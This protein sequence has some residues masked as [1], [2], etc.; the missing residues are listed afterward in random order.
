MK[1][2]IFLSLI[3]AGLTSCDLLDELIPDVET[4]YERNFHISITDNS[5]FTELELIDVASSEDYAEFQDNINGYEITSIVIS[6]TAYNGPED[7]YFNGTI[8]ARD[9]TLTVSVDVADIPHT[10]ISTLLASES[11]FDVEEIAE[12]IDQVI[13]W[14]DDPGKF[15]AQ[16]S[17]NLTDAMGE[18]YPVSDEDY[19]IDLMV[20]YYVTVITGAGSSSEEE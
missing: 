1:K 10:N 20:K 16:A 4:D 17:Y 8:L 14:L 13:N 15:Y 6:V 2:W 7:M 9:T 12:G 5:G 18:P 19:S 11:E 3:I